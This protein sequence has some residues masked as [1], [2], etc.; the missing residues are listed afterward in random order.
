MGSFI[1]IVLNLYNYIDSDVG[2]YDNDG[3]VKSLESA[4]LQ[5]AF[6]VLTGLFD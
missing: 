5:G 4:R 2:F 1:I 3:L 6:D